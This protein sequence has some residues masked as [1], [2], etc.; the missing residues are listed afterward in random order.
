MYGYSLEQRHFKT[1]T[2]HQLRKKKDYDSEFYDELPEEYGEIRETLHKSSKEEAKEYM[3]DVY[4]MIIRWCKDEPTLT[5]G[6][7]SKGQNKSKTMNAKSDNNNE[8][9]SGNSVHSD[10]SISSC[11]TDV[12]LTRT[13]IK[14]PKSVKVKTPSIS[15]KSSYNK[16]SKNQVNNDLISFDDGLS[17]NEF[18]DKLQ[19]SSHQYLPT[20]NSQR[21]SS[22]FNAP[23]SPLDRHKYYPGCNSGIQGA[24]NASPSDQEKFMAGVSQQGVQSR[25]KAPV[26][27]HAAH[28]TPLTRNIHATPTVTFN[29]NPV[30]TQRGYVTSGNNIVMEKL[31]L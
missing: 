24:M 10:S 17:L 8:N 31:Q 21:K 4:K 29:S 13:K 1:Q 18:H 22:G 6:E 20:W 27:P 19:K 15:N 25:K 3:I 7:S 23:I 28:Q 30:S 9:I 26:T 2:W 12:N 14:P 16:S 11:E 5:D